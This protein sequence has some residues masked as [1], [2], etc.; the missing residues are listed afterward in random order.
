MSS[1]AFSFFKL[2]QVQPYTIEGHFAY[3]YFSYCF[4]M[5]TWQHFVYNVFFHSSW[6]RNKET[7]IICKIMLDC[8]K[9]LCVCVGGGGIFVFLIEIHK[10]KWVWRHWNVKMTYY[11]MTYKTLRNRTHNILMV[12]DRYI[13]V[14][15]WVNF[16]LKIKSDKLEFLHLRLIRIIY[17]IVLSR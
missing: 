6:S 2:F 11:W 9:N 12:R 5:L 15:S 16:R 1:S 4:T 14:Q 10:R 17:I 8:A 7:W 13:T 3:K